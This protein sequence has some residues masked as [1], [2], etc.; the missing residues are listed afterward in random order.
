MTVRP[1]SAPA[2]PALN[3][4]ILSFGGVVGL[5]LCRFAYALVLPDMRANLGWNYAEA[6]FMNTINA[7]GY[8]AGALAATR[9]I[10]RFGQFSAVWWGTAICVVALFASAA[11]GNFLLLSLARTLA[12]VGAAL[13]FVGGGTLAATIAQTH[14]AHAA[15]LLG[16]FYTGPGTGV[17]ISGLVVPGLLASFGA[18]SWWVAWLALGVIAAV[19]LATLPAARQQR[20]TPTG[21]AASA[22]VALMPMMPMLIGYLLFGAGYIAYLT[23]MIAWVRD[24]GGGTWEQSVFWCLIGAG[25]I[26]SPWTWSHMLARTKSGRGTAALLAVT[27]VGAI[28]PLLAA[29]PLMLALSAIVF[30]NSFLAVVTS[31]TAFIRHNYPIDTWPGAI[32]AMT[33]AFSI[34]QT[35]GPVLTGAIT[36]AAGSLSFALVT[37]AALLAVG[38]VVAAAQRQLTVR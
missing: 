11:S 28:L 34:G 7:V 13:A 27:L 3:V 25:A 14:P 5:G 10:R 36:D 22:P 6:G 16:L 8:L 26:A 9:Y 29:G 33:I 15:R 31:T 24:A 12:G 30:G 17:M 2:H 1:S 18:G 19:A 4:L 23:F 20:I 35:L 37:S 38:T 21:A 32:A